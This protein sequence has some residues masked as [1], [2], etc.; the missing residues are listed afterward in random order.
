VGRV[1]ELGKKENGVGIG[2]RIVVEPAI[3]CGECAFCRRGSP[4]M[5]INSTTLGIYIDGGFAEYSRVPLSS[6]HK[7]NPQLSPEIAVF[8][9]PLSCVVNAMNRLKPKPADSVLVF[10]AGPIG[11]LFAKLLRAIGVG[12]IYISE[13]SPYRKEIARKCGFTNIIDPIKENVEEYIYSNTGLGVDIVVDCVGNLMNQ[14]LKCVIKGGKILLF[15]LNS[16]AHNDIQPFDIVHKEVDII[17]S[18]IAK[19]TFPT[20]VKI[21]ENGIIDVKDLITHR[22]GIKEF[23]K[24]VETMRSGEA[25]KVVIDF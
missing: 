6:V 15:G 19:F 5:C 20:A 1:V 18:F 17:G 10:G 14:A 7:I 13:L 22:Y 8:T 2:D 9:E 12:N 25:M 16:T 23:K 24:G 21:L 4:N 3:V 11:L